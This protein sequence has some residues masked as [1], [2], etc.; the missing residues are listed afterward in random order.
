MNK[1]LIACISFFIVFPCIVNAQT[2]QH[3]D[4]MNIRM[5]NREGEI[6]LNKRLIEQID[7]GTF[8]ND[9]ISVSKN[10]LDVDET[11]P[12]HISD[13]IQNRGAVL[14]RRPFTI[15]N[16]LAM[17]K[18]SSGQIF[19]YAA[20]NPFFKYNANTTIPSNWAKSPLDPGI[21][22]SVVEIEATGL[23]YE[24]FSDHL[25]G[26]HG[27]GWVRQSG[28]SGVD[29]LTVFTKDFWDFKGKKNRTRTKEVLDAYGDSITILIQHPVNSIQ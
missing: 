23:R 29:L 14:L 21:R 3:K 16:I 28:P 5:L 26:T 20:E 25:H 6:K 11:L 9:P 4:S 15:Y 1:Y 8:I 17:G 27:S 10:H 2:F 13:S 12:F 18:A 7:F 24:I 22:R 19:T